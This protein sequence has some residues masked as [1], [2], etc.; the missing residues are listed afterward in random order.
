MSPYLSREEYVKEG[1]DRD[2][3]ENNEIWEKVFY[4]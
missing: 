2:F 4:I 3:A 1:G